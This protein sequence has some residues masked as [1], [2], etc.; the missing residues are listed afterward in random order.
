MA[1]HRLRAELL[2]VHRWPVERR[3]H[4]RLAGE[5]RRPAGDPLCRGS[6]RRRS[7]GS[8]PRAGASPNPSSTSPAAGASISSIPTA[9]SWRSGRSDSQ[10]LSRFARLTSASGRRG[11][12]HGRQSPRLA[13]RRRGGRF[14]GRRPA[15]PSPPARRPGLTAAVER[16]AA[17]PATAS[18]LIDAADPKGGWTA[19]HDPAAVLFIGSAVKTF[20]LAQYLREVEAGRLSESDQRRDRRC[21]ALA[22]QPRVSQPHRHDPGPQRAGSHDRP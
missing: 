11:N 21:G 4:H 6:R 8:R 10:P 18:C 5:A 15:R 2:R 14:R 9:M 19:G 1:L 7:A 20:I 16:F 3:L 22:Q 13:D 12:T 17:L